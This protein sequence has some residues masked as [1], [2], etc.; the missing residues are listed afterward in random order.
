MNR[1]KGVSQSTPVT[2]QSN[3]DEVT[4]HHNC[5][6]LL[7]AGDVRRAKE[8]HQVAGDSS[9]DCGIAEHNRGITDCLARADRQVGSN[10]PSLNAG[11]REYDEKSPPL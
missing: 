9:G 11:H 4:R 7:P 8:D 2:T 1:I 6:L 5:Y 3:D 10:S